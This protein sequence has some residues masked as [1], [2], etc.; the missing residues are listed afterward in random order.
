MTAR[1]GYSGRF[2]GVVALRLLGGFEIRLDGRQVATAWRSRRARE[3]VQFLSL[4][5]GLALPRDIVI[6][7]LWPRLDAVAGGAN[8]RKAAH[9]ARHSIGVANAVELQQD[10]VRLF[11]GAQITT[12]M[13]AFEAA[14]DEALAD[15]TASCAR[16]AAALYTGE[17][18]PEARYE[19]WADDDRRRLNEKYLELLR[20][21]ENWGE[22]VERDPSDEMACQHLMRFYLANGQR[23]R[24]ITCYGRL[25]AAL[26]H[27]IGLMPNAESQ[28]LY[29]EC[30]SGFVTPTPMFV[31]RA[32]ELIA[33]DMVLSSGDIRRAALW[34][35]GPGG[36]GKTALCTQVAARAQMAGWATVSVVGAEGEDSYATLARLADRLI[37]ADPARLTRL[38]ARSR[39]VLAVLTPSV[40]PVERLETPLTRHQ[41]V[42]AVQQLIESSTASQGLVIVVDDAHYVDQASLDAIGQLGD[43]LEP[44]LVVVLASRPGRAMDSVR[45]CAARAA[46]ANSPLVF[47]L[48]PFDRGDVRVLAQAIAGRMEEAELDALVAHT[49]GL[50]FLVCELARLG[51]PFQESRVRRPVKEAVGQRLSSFDPDMM[52][53]LRRLAVVSDPLDLSRVLALVGCCEADATRLLDEALAAGVLQVDEGEYRF[54]HELIREALADDVPPHHRVAIHRETARRLIEL[55]ARPAIIARHLSQGGR[56]GEAVPWFVRAAQDALKIGAYAAAI[57]LSESALEHAADHLDALLCRARALDALGDLRA[58]AAYAQAERAASE[59]ARQEIVPLHALAQIKQ[60]DPASAIRILDG[61]RPSG[62]EARLAQALTWS[63]A[64]LLGATTPDVGSRLSAEGRRLALES[65]DPGSV[66]VASWAQAAAAHARGELRDSLWADL[67]DTSALPRLAIN[68]F[69]G[70][71]C[72]TERL[73][74]GDRP[75]DDVIEFA[76]A[77][78]AES[79]KIGAVRGAAFG[80]TLCGEAELLSGRL[81]AADADLREAC[82]MHRSMHAPTGTAFV[83]QRRAEVL[84]QRGDLAGA[85]RL[86]EEAL[87]IARE[88]DVGFHLFD[89]I[90]GTQIA[91]ALDSDAGRAAHIANDA[92]ELVQGPFETCPGCRIT[93]AVP[94]AIAAA[95]VGDLERLESLGR[96][97]EFLANTVM[98]LPAWYA[99]LDEV[100]AH[101]CL[102]H[103]NPDAACE[104]FAAA[105]A[106]FAAVGQPFDQAR[107][108]RWQMKTSSSASNSDG[109]RRRRSP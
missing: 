60:G 70:Q 46:R 57:E 92:Y 41:V 16:S 86:L 71:L 15:G 84:F 31:G 79:R 101:G 81:D 89:R 37:A 96:T 65:G 6:D 48:A 61:V 90:Y 52:A 32:A 35:R 83:M 45:R 14:A 33:V 72:I 88:S 67:R 29:A 47:D 25:R 109:R 64:A 28:R 17:L 22:L 36:I 80:R 106:Q 38:S 5:P 42:G 62:L 94:A 59:E 108:E 105:A 76:K 27:D 85:E 11:P 102:A 40:L 8:L 39:S 78:E 69:D 12:D 100:R 55:G 73:L 4:A 18:L 98:H 99:A 75:Y 54:R 74:Y 21:S 2:T 82:Q 34:F 53:R 9:H 91:V 77:F 68:V 30:L 66:I 44:R 7:T 58:L 26:Q 50:P 13:C 63:G 3:L 43:R 93:L 20:A 56:G 103:G 49:D 104:R 95:R 23:H 24:A 87:A 51:P 97:C 19:S 1:N 107:C 10:T